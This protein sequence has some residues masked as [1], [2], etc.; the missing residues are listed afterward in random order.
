VTWARLLIIMAIALATFC[1]PQLE[2]YETL[3]RFMSPDEA[4]R[5][6]I[7]GFVDIALTPWAIAGV[8]CSVLVLFCIKPRKDVALL[9]AFLAISYL[10]LK[11][12]LGRDLVIIGPYSLLTIILWLYVAVSTYKAAKL[13]EAP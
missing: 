10:V 5:I 7:T 8:A 6:L 2:L 3:V 13:W 12:V 11:A 9:I 1:L 4:L